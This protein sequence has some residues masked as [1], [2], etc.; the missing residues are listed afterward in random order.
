[1]SCA[2]P[3]GDV[4]GA[5]SGGSRRGRDRPRYASPKHTE[6]LAPSWGLPPPRKLRSAAVALD[7]HTPVLVGVGQVTER[8]DPEVAITERAEPVELMARALSAAAEDCGTGAAGRALLDRA[9][10]LRVMVPLSWRYE[11][12]GLLVAQRLGIAPQE[13]ALT[14]IGGNNPQ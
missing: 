5:R 12:P 13:L 6:G 14:A 4:R 8:P 2:G 10:S 1:M 11:N 3:V 9:Q 7:P